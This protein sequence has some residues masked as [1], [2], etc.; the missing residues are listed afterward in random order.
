MKL[1]WMI[2]WQTSLVQFTAYALECYKQLGSKSMR[3][4]EICEEEDKFCAEVRPACEWN[5]DEMILQFKLVSQAGRSS[6][7]FLQDYNLVAG[8]SNTVRDLARAPIES[9]CKGNM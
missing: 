7:H 4:T 9:L 1:N 8:C 5:V 3:T 2:I 6:F